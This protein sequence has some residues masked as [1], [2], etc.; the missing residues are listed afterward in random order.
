MISVLPSSVHL[1]L[2]IEIIHIV[3]SGT[4][5]YVC[6]LLLLEMFCAED[7]FKQMGVLI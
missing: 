6:I 2:E 4:M 3:I 5:L 1:N 7:T